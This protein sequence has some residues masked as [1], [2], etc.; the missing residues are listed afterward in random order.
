MD[1]V[2]SEIGPHAEAAFKLERWMY[3][4]AR[5]HGNKASRTPT[6][7]LKQQPWNLELYCIEEQNY[8]NTEFSLRRRNAS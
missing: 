2:G 1:V 8:H 4:R 5:P 6:G 7:V 3:R